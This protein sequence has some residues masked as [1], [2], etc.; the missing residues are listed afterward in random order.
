[1]AETDPNFDQWRG[2]IS[3][4]VAEHRRRLDNHDTDIRELRVS[5]N[6]ATLEIAKLGTSVEGLRGDIHRALATQAEQRAAEFAELQ[7]TVA[8]A[9][10]TPKERLIWITLPLILAMISAFVILFT[11]HTL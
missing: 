3:V 4:K 5:A 2:E 6:A 8:G 10:I 9:K 1:M 7:A 11:T